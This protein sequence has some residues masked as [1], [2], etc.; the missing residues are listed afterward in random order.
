MS[1]K[2]AKSPKSAPSVIVFETSHA[3]INISD[4]A[5][6]HDRNHNGKGNESLEAI[7]DSMKANIAAG[8]PAVDHDIDV[9]LAPEGAEKPYLIGAGRRRIEASLKLGLTQVPAKIWPV[10][11]NPLTLAFR[12][13]MLRKGLEPFEKIDQLIAMRKGDEVKGAKP[14]SDAEII[15]ETGLAKTTVQ[16]ILRCGEKVKGSAR[17][18]AISHDISLQNIATAAQFESEA[19]QIATMTKLA[20]GEGKRIKKEK[21]DAAPDEKPSKDEGYEGP[22][23]PAVP[24]PPPDAL[25]AALSKI[26]KA[27]AD[28]ID[29]ACCGAWNKPS[30]DAL[31]VL[32]G[33]IARAC[34]ATTDD[35]QE[36]PVQEA[37]ANL[38]TLPKSA[39]ASLE[40]QGPGAFW[41]W[42]RKRLCFASRVC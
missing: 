31:L 27:L 34:P 3:V 24:A 23:A 42:P 30:Q 4:I 2:P 22:S 28:E 12:E 41:L 35:A 11:T 39:P 14:M 40:N 7:V 36:A 21:T 6:A 37:A 15:A 18:F 29:A 19:D 5:W 38:Q 17:M 32:L 33:A 8:R 25:K 1:K 16:N 26:D 10:G 13:N 20:A 9:I